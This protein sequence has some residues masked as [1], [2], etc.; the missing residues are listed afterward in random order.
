MM[1]NLSSKPTIN[2]VLKDKS[3]GQTCD[4]LII[5]QFSVNKSSLKGENA[6]LTHFKQSLE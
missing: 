3:G 2:V 1:A 6:V 5:D 4:P